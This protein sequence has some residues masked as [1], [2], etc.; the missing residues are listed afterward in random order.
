[1]RDRPARWR[2][3]EFIREYVREHGYGPIMANIAEG[4]HLSPHTVKHHLGG[5]H[6]DGHITL[7]VYGR[8]IDVTD[9]GATC[10]RCGKE[11]Q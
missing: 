6:R 11:T 9:D 8:Q 2:V 7:G 1:M 3:Y 5:L 10:L 4:M